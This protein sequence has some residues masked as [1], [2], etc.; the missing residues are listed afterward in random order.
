MSGA[1]VLDAAARALLDRSR[2]ARLA[3]ADARARPHV[4]PFCYAREDDRI[5]FVVDDKPKA[6]GRVLKRIRNLLEN[7]EVALVA[8]VWDE[9][10]SRLEYVL[11]W[12]R[13]ALVEDAAEAA[14]AIEALRRRYPQY[15]SMD[16]APGRSPVVRIEAR[17]AHRWA[18]R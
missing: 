2:V 8:D 5:Y 16:L 18:A 11:V 14:A 9:D 1:A 13:A 7:P 15:R 3:T 17:S 6:P 12:G 10:W 4:V